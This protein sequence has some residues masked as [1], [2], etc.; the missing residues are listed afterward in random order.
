MA[1]H[2]M[3]NRYICKLC[4]LRMVCAKFSRVLFSPEHY[5]NATELHVCISVRMT[6][7][8]AVLP[9]SRVR[10]RGSERSYRLRMPSL[11]DRPARMHHR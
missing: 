3:H 11:R 2:T 6:M 10:N 9:F 7:V 5:L 8:Q 1:M 4:F